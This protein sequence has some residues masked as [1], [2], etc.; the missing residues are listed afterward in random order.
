MNFKLISIWGPN[1]LNRIEVN[2]VRFSYWIHSV[3]FEKF[4]NKK[5]D[6][7]NKKKYYKINKTKPITPLP[8]RMSFYWSAFLICPTALNQAL[9]N[10][11]NEIKP[12]ADQI[13]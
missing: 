2:F 12:D 3:P 13:E 5:F 7:G 1:Q 6:L 4:S 10:N 8:V 9:K 11:E